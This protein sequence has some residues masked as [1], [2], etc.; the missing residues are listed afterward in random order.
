MKKR[1]FT[2]I[3]LLVVIAIIVILAGLLLSV[4]G[5]IREK[6]RSTSCANN[7][8]QNGMAFG[9][10]QM[11]YNDWTA[12]NYYNGT[13]TTK[14]WAEFNFGKYTDP[15]YKGVLGA[16]TR[17]PS[18]RHPAGEPQ[19]HQQYIYGALG[20]VFSKEK[21]GSKFYETSAG[22]F[23]SAGASTTASLFVFVPKV[24]LAAEFPMLADSIADNKKYGKVQR[25]IF[26]HDG[27]EAALNLVHT[28]SANLL[29]ADGHTGLLKQDKA[30]EHGFAKYHLDGKYEVSPN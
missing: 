11:S 20:F 8:K 4:I 28:Q 18:V 13:G 23:T 3:E 14:T 19:N 27:S 21:P 30:Y 5:N 10:Y 2:L 29:Y 7:M 1:S 9:I 12:L 17:C 15:D 16:S 22:A 6:A 26:K 24:K 25:Y